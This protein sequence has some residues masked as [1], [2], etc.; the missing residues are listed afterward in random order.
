MWIWSIFFANFTDA[1]FIS[2]TFIN[3]LFNRW[4]RKVSIIV[5]TIPSIFDIRLAPTRVT[6]RVSQMEHD[7]LKFSDHLKTQCFYWGHGAQ[8]YI[9]FF[10]VFFCFFF[11]LLLCWFSSTYKFQ[12]PFGFFRLS[13]VYTE[14]NVLL[15]SGNPDIECC[16]GNKPI[17]R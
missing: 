12:Y 4:Q 17:S 5:I 1:I 13:F 2:L 8:Y 16:D 14:M 3:Y 10:F 11:C 7:P 6:R 9:L 15:Y